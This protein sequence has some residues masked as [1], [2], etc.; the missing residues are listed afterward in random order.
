MN[1]WVGDELNYL[2]NRVK[3]RDKRDDEEDIGEEE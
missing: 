3:V 2:L 1:V